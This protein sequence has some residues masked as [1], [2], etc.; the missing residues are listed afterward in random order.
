[1]TLLG[2]SVIL[3]QPYSWTRECPY[4]LLLAWV[5][6]SPLAI[7]IIAATFFPNFTFKKGP[8]RPFRYC[9]TADKPLQKRLSDIHNNS[10][11]RNGTPWSTSIQHPTSSALA[12]QSNVLR[13]SSSPETL[14]PSH[15]KVSSA[16][17]TPRMAR[18]KL[19]HIPF[20]DEIDHSLTSRT[21]NEPA[22]TGLVSGIKRIDDEGY[23]GDDE[24]IQLR[25]PHM[26]TLMSSLSPPLIYP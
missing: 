10:T 25:A 23:A 5:C 19:S 9:T 15:L 21:L 6:I 13:C 4:S 2:V 12:T 3:Y 18:K 8:D 24:G 14:S 26:Y 16:S 7:P 11:Y 20:G 22:D 17:P 1:M